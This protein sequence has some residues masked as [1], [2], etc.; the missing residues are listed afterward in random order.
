M[1]KKYNF[2]Y[3][4]TNL[5]N[6]KQYVGDHCTNN[7]EDKYLGSGRTF[8]KALK[9]YGS[10]NFKTEILEFFANKKEA[11]TAQEKYIIKYNTISPNGYNISPKGGH[12]SKG[13]MSEETKEKLRKINIGNKN[14]PIIGR[15]FKDFYIEKYGE[16][17]GL[18]KYLILKKKWHEAHKGETHIIS[19][20]SRKKM[21]ETHKGKKLTEEHKLKVS[22]AL[23]GKKK[24][25]RSL[26]HRNN[27][28]KANKGRKHT[29]IAILNMGNGKRGSTRTDE[30]K[31][32]ISNS[33][34]GRK[35]SPEH[36]AKLSEIR[37]L[38]YKKKS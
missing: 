5:L 31:K 21:S 34:K 29:E 13:S 14:S 4:T 27:I 25:E 24:P 28:S 6:G 38:K 15:T 22:L 16:E 26:E 20:E 17:E 8:L 1:E 9:K 3:L 2:V 35:L 7:I 36:K 30:Q 18:K 12:F 19:D 33:L 37:K 23:K 10:E 32:N 11:F